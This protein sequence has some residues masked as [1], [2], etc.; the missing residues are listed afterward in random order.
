VR[1]KF[2]VARPFRPQAASRR[3]A[4]VGKSHFLDL[5]DATGRIQIYIHAERSRPGTGRPFSVARSWR[6]IGRGG[7]LFVTKSGNRHWKVRTFQLLA[8]AFAAAS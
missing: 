1:E 3:I 6:F 4:T 5:R 8:K 2:K 7:N